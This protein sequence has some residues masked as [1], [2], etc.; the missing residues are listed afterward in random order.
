MTTRNR[1]DESTCESVCVSRGA[2]CP[3]RSTRKPA[4]KEGQHVCVAK[5][6]HRTHEGDDD[7]DDHEDK[8]FEPVKRERVSRR[9]EGKAEMGY[10]THQFVLPS[11]IAQLTPTML[12]KSTSVWNSSCGS[13]RS[14]WATVISETCTAGSA[15][16]EGKRTKYCKAPNVSFL[17]LQRRKGRTHE[18]QW[19]ANTP[20]EQD[21]NR[22]DEEGDLDRTADSD[23]HREVQLVLRSD[24]DSLLN[25]SY[26]REV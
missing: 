24:G 19:L 10:W 15:A 14:D 23:R 16:S 18:G 4:R 5:E 21:Q 3:G 6:W 26:Q 13:K 22:N 9:S 12:T 8:A 2:A 17:N 1:V 20:T 25:T 7:I 11:A